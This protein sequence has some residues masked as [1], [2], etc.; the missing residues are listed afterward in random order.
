M[1]SSDPPRALAWC[2]SANAA[3]DPRGKER[4]GDAIADREALHVAADLDDLAGAVGCWNDPLGPLLRSARDHQVAIVQ[5]YRSHADAHVAG[6]DIRPRHGQRASTSRSRL[7]DGARMLSR[8][9]PRI[10][11]EIDHDKS[12]GVHEAVRKD[13]RP[14]I[15]S[16]RQVDASEDEP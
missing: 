16:G 4:R 8:G 6:A 11:T 13:A 14:E 2:S 12:N 9:D 15:P 7:Q 5:R 3:V 10:D 1:P